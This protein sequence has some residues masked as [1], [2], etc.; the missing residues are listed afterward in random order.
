MY[1]RCSV[2]R[3][4]VDKKLREYVYMKRV[5]TCC[6]YTN[7]KHILEK[8]VAVYVCFEFAPHL[9]SVAPPAR[10]SSAPFIRFLAE[11]KSLVR[12]R[13]CCGLETVCAR[14]QFG[15]LDI[16]VENPRVSAKNEMQTSSAECVGVT[17]RSHRV[18]AQF[19]ER[20]KL[21]MSK[22]EEALFN[23]TVNAPVG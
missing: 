17:Q 5:N 9:I 23:D 2:I 19:Y 13:C 3:A 11:I 4:E 12:V 10:C 7:I 22:K 21:L 20:E 18:C 1:L 16:T 14:A 6:I 8:V 15:F